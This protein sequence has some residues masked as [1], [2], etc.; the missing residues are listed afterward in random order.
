MKSKGQGLTFFLLIM[1]AVTTATVL[2]M[3][4]QTQED[5]KSARRT[6]QEKERAFPIV[7]FDEPE[8]IDKEV[9]EKRQTRSKRYDKYSGQRIEQSSVSFTRIASSDWA[10]RL[11]AI[12]VAE[13]DVI[14]A[15]TVT[16]AAAHL[17]NDKTAVYSEF[18]CRV[19]DVLK[20]Q[21]TSVAIGV[22]LVLQRFGGIVR[23]PNGTTFTT[24]TVGQG[25]PVTG[26]QY[27]FF[28]KGLDETN[29]F[30]IIT[31]YEVSGLQVTPLDGS[32]ADEGTR[33]Y[34]FDQYQRYE[35]ALLLKVIKEAI[36]HI[37]D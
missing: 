19:D 34:A 3:H 31:A 1:A 24:E 17:S 15:G 21:R 6:R 25:M 37:G 30:R 36:E 11:P 2:G 33:R 20:S 28:L 26:G 8:P 32:I 23:F 5:V 29:D 18:D 27:V 4:S 35:P 10:N 9:R 7:D 22:T 12:P 14:V 13:S 16:H